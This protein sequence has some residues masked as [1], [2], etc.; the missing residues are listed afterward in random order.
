MAIQGG[1]AVSLNLPRNFVGQL[2]DDLDW[3]I[4]EWDNT[5]DYMEHGV[6]RDGM[7]IRECNDAREA[8][9]MRDS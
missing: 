4:E 5:A 9:K 3:L 7:M 8:Q 1:Q 2:L 6:S